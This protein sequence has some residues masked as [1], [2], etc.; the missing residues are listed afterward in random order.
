MDNP[1]LGRWVMHQKAQF[2]KYEEDPATSTLSAERFSAL[3]HMGATSSW[4]AASLIR[5]MHTEARTWEESRARLEAYRDAHKG[6]CNVPQRWKEDPQLGS[7]VRRQKAQLRKY[8]EDPATSTLSAE[9]VSAL[10]QMGA[11]DSWRKRKSR[12]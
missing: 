1:Q 7:W 12:A 3:Q 11:I 8:E 4:L 2:R 10:Q 9:R 6:C 5:S